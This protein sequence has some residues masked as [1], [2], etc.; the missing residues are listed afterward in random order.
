MK[1][2][3]L[4]TLAFCAV[5]TGCARAP[6]GNAADATGWQVH[7]EHLQWLGRAAPP[8]MRIGTVG[9]AD[10]R[11]VHAAGRIVW[12]DHCTARVFTPVNGRIEALLAEPGARVRRGQPLLELSSGDFGQWQVDLRKAQADALA[13]RRADARARDLLAVGVMAQRDAEQAQAD[14]Q[15]AEAE[16]DRA[17]ARLQQLGERSDAVNGRFV[18]RSPLDGVIVDRVATAGTEVRA[19]ASMPLFVITDP[20]Q[21]NIV[22]DLPE[23]LAPSVK[24]GMELKFM[25]SGPGMSP[26]RA[27]LTAVPAA[28]DPIT[29]TVR[30][31]GLVISASTGIPGEAY[32]Q[33]D[34]PVAPSHGAT[35]LVPSDALVL[36][37]SNY[38]VYA[39]SGQQYQRRPVTIGEL[40]N[41]LVEV[42]AGLQVG[43]SIVV[44][45]SL[46]LEQLLEQG[47]EG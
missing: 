1:V 23:Y 26:G 35:V 13:A 25:R 42:S 29:R 40:G 20:S 2:L 44:D 39:V 45:G 43:E 46:Y 18:L 34:I 22:V 5:V 31:R 16:L 9:A 3:W 24:A 8:F 33:V 30:A 41:P 15:R 12:N 4:T 47:T 19:D 7:G 36:V 21:L 6:A 11:V 32:V 17:E 10:G 14:R 28:V 27:R 38:Y 37:G